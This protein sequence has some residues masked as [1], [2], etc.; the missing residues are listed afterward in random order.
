M[1]REGMLTHDDESAR[2]RGLV[3][4][5]N[6]AIGTIQVDPMSYQDAMTW[7]THYENGELGDHY[8]LPEPLSGQWAGESL[9]ELGMG[10]W[11]DDML[12]QYEESFLEAW[13]DTYLAYA[14][15]VIGAAA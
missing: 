10:D 15:N 5:T 7:I 12:S 6:N 9:I 11:D 14:R 4:G 2:Q 1:T 8:A 13:L 3:D